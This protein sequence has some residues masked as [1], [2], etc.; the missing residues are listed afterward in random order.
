MRNERTGVG[1]WGL[2]TGEKA[3]VK[4][5]GVVAPWRLAVLALALAGWLL[6]GL[7]GAWAGQPRSLVIERFEADIVVEPGG[8]ITVTETIRP[9]FVGSWN[10]IFRTIPVEYRTPQGL[11]YSLP[12]EVLAVT[13]DGGTPLRYTE[14]RERHNRTIKIWVP[15][16]QDAVRTV[17]LRYRAWNALEFFAEHDELYW[18]VT[19]DEWQAPIRSAG[20]TIKLPA[21]VTGLRAVA[22]TGGYGSR[23]QDA[24][25]DIGSEEIRVEAARSL[26]FREGL[27]IAAGWDP[28]VVHRPGRVE[29]AALFLRS[30]WML[31]LPLLALGGM[32]ALWY[33][34]GR[35]PR[36]RPIAPQYEPPEGLTAAELGTLV[37]NSP[38]LRDITATMVDLAVRG[39][40]RIEE[41]E[42]TKLLGLLS[43]TDYRF[44]LVK[45]EVEWAGLQPHEQAL[46]DALFL[47]GR[48]KSVDISGLH[49]SFYRSLPG[50]R[51]QIFV[52]LLQRGYYRQRPDRVRATYLAV[53]AAAGMLMAAGGT[54]LAERMGTAPLTAILAGL[55][56]AAIMAG[57]GWVMPA[58]TFRGARVLEGVLGFEEFLDRVEG[59]RL[60]RVAKTPELFEK[61]L[62]YA[63]ALGVERNWARAFETIY[64]Q[65]PEWYHGRHPGTFQTHVLTSRLGQMASRT[66]T[67]MASSP[68]STGGS[69]FGGGGSSGGGRG[70]GGGGGF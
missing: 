20:A 62:P 56:T 38:D 66:G 9:R 46:L 33:A 21:G 55:L 57:V 8:A 65:P 28:G 49:N 44:T 63:M 58:R 35:D 60:A 68:R 27:T 59:D 37:D 41:E 50:I 11:N 5:G 36:R 13:D 16:A 54:W 10:G 53:A 51:D 19:G 2:G 18:N 6:A 25:L 17:V 61:F 32:F 52:R 7:P 48:R 42:E 23:E 69:G 34:K 39:Y 26:G 64:R 24:R 70:G 43:S 15:G 40:L 45:P 31:L 3:S 14:K 67:A 22:Y 47:G 29:Q 1:G 30:N 12:L 4:R